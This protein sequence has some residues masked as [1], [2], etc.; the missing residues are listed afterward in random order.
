MF[1]IKKLYIYIFSCCYTY[2]NNYG[3]LLRFSIF[4][5]Y[6]VWDLRKYMAN[7]LLKKNKR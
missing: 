3:V 5:L 7:I 4:H 6:F 2:N 1:Y